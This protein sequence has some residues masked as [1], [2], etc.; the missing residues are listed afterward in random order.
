[1]QCVYVAL[2]SEFSSDFSKE[3]RR[4]GLLFPL[5]S[6]PSD[7]RYSRSATTLHPKFWQ[8]QER[9]KC[10]WGM[11]NVIAGILLPVSALASAMSAVPALPLMCPPET[12][13]IRWLRRKFA[14][15]A[16]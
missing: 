6:Y 15:L 9:S 4:S 8:A 10:R 3:I 2:R 11:S 13:S 14:T 1:M 5:S 7:M 12:V 16:T